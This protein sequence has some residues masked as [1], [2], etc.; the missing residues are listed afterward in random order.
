VSAEATVHRR[1]FPDLGDVASGVTAVFVDPKA[2]A[3]IKLGLAG[4]LALYIS[5]LIRLDHANWAL[6]TVI[7]SAPSQ[8]VGAIAQRSIARVSYT[9]AVVSLEIRRA[10]L[11]RSSALG[12]RTPGA[13]LSAG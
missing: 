5:R 11:Y 6:F 4:M 13:Q 12:E 2:V 1:R 8:Y 7:V 10:H 3:G 9:M